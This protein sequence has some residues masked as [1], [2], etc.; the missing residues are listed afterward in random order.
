[1][2]HL[3]PKGGG[4]TSFLHGKV[5]DMLYFP[6]ISTTLPSW[7]PI[8]GGKQFDFFEPVFNIADASISV[9]VFIILVFQN[10]F[11]KKEVHSIN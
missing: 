9:G 3:F 4:Y 2:A 10:I 11:F 8:M 1:M 5:V 6:L 7:I